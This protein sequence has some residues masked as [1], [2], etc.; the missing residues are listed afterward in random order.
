[1][2]CCGALARVRNDALDARRERGRGQ[3]SGDAVDEV[4]GGPDPAA[5]HALATHHLCDLC[6]A[7]HHV[8][9]RV[10]I[11]PNSSLM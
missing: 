4:R 8:T 3:P 2:E 10:S 1:M 5:E 9:S 11:E 6:G 7:D